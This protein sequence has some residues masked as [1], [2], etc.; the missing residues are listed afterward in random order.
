MC[1]DNCNVLARRGWN[2]SH[3]HQPTL[4][5]YNG[6]MPA[7]SARY[8]QT[9][10]CSDCMLRMPG[11]ICGVLFAGGEPHSAANLQ[12][13]TL[14]VAQSHKFAPKR[15]AIY[16]ANEQ[17]NSVAIVCGGWACS[18]IP[19][20]NGNRQILSFLLPGDITSAAAV[21]QDRSEISI[22]AVTDV[23]YCLVSKADLKGALAANRNFFDRFSKLWVRK[24][25]EVERLA[26]DLGHRTAEERIA[27][28]IL[29]LLER[30]RE[31]NLVHQERFAFPLRLQHIADA[32]GLTVVH[33]SRVIG[34]MRRLG[35]IEIEER[36]LTVLDLRELQNISN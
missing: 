2:L 23:H 22:E 4:R 8:G 7:P 10:R 28:L 25:D 11:S 18:Y 14:P 27:R 24:N 30:H 36:F 15:R 1:V 35:V 17:S 3:Y 16:R 19:L 33:V 9:S 29:T 13:G 21:F 12:S 31:R 34:M 32:M 5:T 6:R 20:R 26:T